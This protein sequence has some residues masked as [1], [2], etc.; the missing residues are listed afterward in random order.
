MSILNI[1]SR[2]TIYFDPASRDHRNHYMTFL[3]KRT[4]RDCPVQFYLERGYGDL[5]AMIENKL[6]VYYLEQEFD[7][8][9]P[10]RS[11]QWAIA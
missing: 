4:W 11:D 3:K 5:A 9:V 7:T 6:S 8:H 2:P 10:E 1:Q